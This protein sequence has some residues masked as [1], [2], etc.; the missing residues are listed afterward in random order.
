MVMRDLIHG[1]LK[2]VRSV[3]VMAIESL[4]NIIRTSRTVGKRQA[5]GK[6]AK[7]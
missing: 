7:A 4:S 1:P 3:G 6:V 2:T 5:C